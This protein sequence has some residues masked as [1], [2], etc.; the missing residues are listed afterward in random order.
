MLILLGLGFEEALAAVR[1]A[2]SD[3]ESVGKAPLLR[4]FH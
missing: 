1:A 2:G 3:P 4:A